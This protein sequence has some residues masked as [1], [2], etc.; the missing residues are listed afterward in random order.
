MKR[1]L[2]KFMALG[3]LALLL[4]AAC[5]KTDAVI[6]TNGGTAGTLTA[7]V[8]TL[9]LNKTKLTDTTAAISFKITNADYGYAAATTNTLQIDLPG[10]NWANPI[11]VTLPTKSTAVRYATADFNALMLKLGFPAGVATQVSARI[12]YS[13]GTSVKTIYSNTV[14]LTVT[15]FNLT[16]YLYVPGAYQG[17]NPATADS[18]TSITGNGIYTGIINFTAGNLNFKLTPAKVF[19]N[20]YGA[21]GSTIIYNGGSDIP[22]PAA[23]LTYITVNLNN[24][25]IT[26][27]AVAH[28]Y[29]LIGDATPGGWS[30]DTDLKFD[31]GLQ[32]WTTTVVLTAAA[33]QAFKFRADHDWLLSFGN[34]ATVDGVN[35]AG[36]GA[37][38]PST[39]A[40]IY[41][42]SLSVA[43]TATPSTA[44]YTMVKK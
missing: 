23:G 5:K 31:N 20:S 30:T 24:N 17:W 41:K 3:S 28:T 1:S 12:A 33:G 29:S 44:T 42:I 25:T 39:V 18:L 2:T 36:N 32:A 40:G 7:S 35:L 43:N 8:T 37:N 11:T 13:V 14:S 26:F 22:A 27:A 6:T 16:S 19:T 21:T 9:P 15:S 38:I 4:L 10:D 34:P